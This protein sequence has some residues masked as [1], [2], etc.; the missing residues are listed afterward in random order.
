MNK[1]ILPLVIAGSMALAACGGSD[2]D[3]EAFDTDRACRIGQRLVD[4]TAAVDRDGVVNQIERLDDLE[5]I[6]DSGLDVDELDELAEG[7]DENAVEDLVAEFEAIGCELE[8]PDVEAP[9]DTEPA[10]TT[11]TTEPPPETVPPTEPPPETV[12]TTE[13]AP[14][15]TVAPETTVAPDTPPAGD[16]NG[17]PIDI[18]ST[19]PGPSLG[20]DRPTEAV[21]A[22]FEI[23]GILFSPNTNVVELNIDR[24]DDSFSDDIE[25]AT[26]DDI[27]MS[28]T[29]TIT[30]EEV[31]AA[32]QAAIDGLG[33]EYDYTESTSSSDGR[34]PSGSRQIRPNSAPTS[35]GGTSASPR[36]TRCRASS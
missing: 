14:D 25:W 29:T 3:T 34:T 5:G 33:F 13:A 19:G 7:L 1:K 11:P 21:L 24:S 9:V 30:L 31:R 23:A 26:A 15:T 32:Y 2:A 18:G 17:I 28:A 8:M 4:E 35:R 12:P 22:E 10:D 6:A 27:T 20:I 16:S 36:T